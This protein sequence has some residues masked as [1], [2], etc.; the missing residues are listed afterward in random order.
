MVLMHYLLL[1]AELIIVLVAA[2]TMV[3]TT[4]QNS[5]SVDLQRRNLLE[6]LVEDIDVVDAGNAIESLRKIPYQ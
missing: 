2:S 4:I 6:L 1:Q 5:L 3:T